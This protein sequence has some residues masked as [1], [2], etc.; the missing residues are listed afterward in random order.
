[1]ALN[2]GTLLIRDVQDADAGWYRCVGVDMNGQQSQSFMTEVN[3]ACKTTFFKH[4]VII[5]LP[6]RLT[7]TEYEKNAYRFFLI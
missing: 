4:I 1:M 7:L 5:D 2:N 6:V 3:I